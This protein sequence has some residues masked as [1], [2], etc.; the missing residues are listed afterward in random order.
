MPEQKEE[1][2]ELYAVRSKDGKY[3]RT[4]GFGGYGESW[5]PDLSTAKIYTKPGPAKAQITYWGTKYPEFGVPDLL[6]L[7]ARVKCVEDH[8]ERVQ[9]HAAEKEI[10]AKK[11]D[12]IAKQDRINRLKKE[13]TD[14]KRNLAALEAEDAPTEEEVLDRGY[15]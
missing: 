4:K 15:M 5:V 10:K 1:V 11:R 8:T 6:I 12:V 14:A 13:L 7:E 3:L 2:V 9:K